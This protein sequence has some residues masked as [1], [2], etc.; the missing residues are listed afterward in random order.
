MSLDKSLVC[1]RPSPFIGMLIYVDNVWSKIVRSDNKYWI[2]ED[3]KTNYKSCEFFKD[4]ESSYDWEHCILLPGEPKCPPIP[5]EIQN[6]LAIGNYI[7]HFIDTQWHY[8]K[9]ELIYSD[10][11]VY[12]HNNQFKAPKG[13]VLPVTFQKENVVEQSLTK[14]LCPREGC[15]NY[16]G[17]GDM[18]VCSFTKNNPCSFCGY[19]GFIQKDNECKHL[20]LRVNY[21]GKVSCF[22]CNA[23]FVFDQKEKEFKPNMVLVRASNHK[24]AKNVDDFIVQHSLITEVSDIDIILKPANN[25]AKPPKGGYGWKKHK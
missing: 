19:P 2:V 17:F 23:E 15:I 8:G 21:F 13:Q 5:E 9:I 10:S 25:D 22:S 24:H 1:I 6:D 20:K 3:L 4:L 11:V 18:S 14:N 12:Y 16:K 7:Y